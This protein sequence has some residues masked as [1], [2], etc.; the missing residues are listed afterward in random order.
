MEPNKLPYIIA[1]EPFNLKDSDL[2][3][4]RLANE[5]I[6]DVSW[7]AIVAL[8]YKRACNHLK[9]QNIKDPDVFERLYKISGSE[10]KSGEYNGCS[11]YYHSPIHASIQSRDADQSALFA[12][13][14]GV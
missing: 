2:I 8:A 3:T 11:F 4:A 13:Y 5:S 10:V 7:R 6:Q 14:V 12:S 9:K 1:A